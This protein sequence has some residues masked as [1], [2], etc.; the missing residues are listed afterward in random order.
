VD[1]EPFQSIVQ[2]PWLGVWMKAKVRYL[3]P[4][5]FASVAGLSEEYASK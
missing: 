1:D 4:E 3:L 2:E 5:A